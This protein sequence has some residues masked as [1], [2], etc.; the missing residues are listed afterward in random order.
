[1]QAHIRPPGLISGTIDDT[2]SKK[3]EVESD[4]ESPLYSE[5]HDKD[6]NLHPCLWKQRSISNAIRLQQRLSTQRE[7]GDHNTDYRRYLICPMK[8]RGH[9]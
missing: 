7:K 4:E 3:S 2:A 6:R 1:M 9:C 8:D 5:A